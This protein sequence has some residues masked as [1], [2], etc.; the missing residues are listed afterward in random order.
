MSILTIDRNTFKQDLTVNSE[1]KALYGEIFTPF[2]LIEK[3][4]NMMDAN[5]FNNP[6]KT[7]MDAGAGSGFFSMALFWRLMD[8]LCDS[9]PNKTE[10]ARHIIKNMLYFSDLRDANVDKLISL[11]GKE[12]NCFHGNYLEYTE[13]QFDYIIGNPPYNCNGIKKV[14]TNKDKNKKQDGKTI[15]VE[16]VKHSISLLKD[17]G[18][19]LFIIPSIWMKPD[20]KKTYDLITR[21]KIKKLICMTNTQT[22]TFFKGEAQTPTCLLYLSKQANDYHVEIY[23][24]DIDQYIDYTYI[25][26][27]PL[28]VFGA[29]VLKK[30]KIHDNKLQL[31]TVHKTNMP[32]KGIILSYN[33]T[34]TQLYPNIR[35]TVLDGLDPKLVIQYSNKPLAFYN[36]KKLIMP[37]KMYGF[38]YIDYDGKYG[39]CNRDSY[40]ICHDNNNTLERLAQFFKTK[41]ALYLFESTR[42]RMKYLE[43]YIFQLL[44]D[45]SNLHNF[46]D[47][48]N[49]E[50]IANYFGY[51]K[52]EIQS[53]QT[54][55]KKNYSFTYD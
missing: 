37:H 1:C 31:P 22:N 29:A 2:K 14:P 26:Q 30:T 47:D 21:Y 8:G 4:L 20:R 55:H 44:P 51:S 53:I 49:D 17:K 45:I 34:K 19:I 6:S 48:I 40:V 52:L 27:E 24:Q 33:K 9:F 32:P 39:I 18:E 10:R 38:P 36:K 15:W 5:I 42:Y 28:P 12:S 3:M 11:F 25:D 54:L 50:T 43:K 35:T 23:D 7:F 46:P 13:R 16:F 41:T